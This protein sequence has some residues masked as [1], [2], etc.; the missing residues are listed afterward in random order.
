MLRSKIVDSRPDSVAKLLL[1]A[2]LCDNFLYNFLPYLFNGEVGNFKINIFVKISHI[3]RKYSYLFALDKQLNLINAA[4]FDCHCG[5]RVKLRTLV[6]D[7]FAGVGVNNS[8]RECSALNSLEKRKLFIEFISSD[9]SEIVT[10]RVKEHIHNKG[11]R[12]FNV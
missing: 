8:L 12:V 3:I 2:A 7:Y 6:R 10:L 4:S 1:C 9:L 5:I 11:F